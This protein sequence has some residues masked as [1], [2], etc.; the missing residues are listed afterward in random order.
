MKNLPPLEKLASLPFY[1]SGT[2]D[3]AEP[4][5]FDCAYAV[6]IW[7]AQQRLALNKLIQ[8]EPN[9]PHSS[10]DGLMHYVPHDPE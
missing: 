5:A 3:V 7:D 8:A 2:S 1:R 6:L 4:P 10:P 9:K